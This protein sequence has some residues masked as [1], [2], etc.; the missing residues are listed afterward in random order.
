MEEFGC[1]F[2]FVNFYDVELVLLLFC[3]IVRLVIMGFCCWRYVNVKWGYMVEV[4]RLNKGDV[5]IEVVMVG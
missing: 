4:S 3:I 1:G 5:D 2:V